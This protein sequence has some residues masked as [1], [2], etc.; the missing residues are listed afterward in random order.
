LREDKHPGFEELNRHSG[1]SYSVITNQSEELCKRKVELSLLESL[2]FE[3]M[4]HRHDSIP[5]AHQRTFE[6]IF[7]DPNTKGKAW[8]DF[9]Q[10]LHSGSG[11]YWIN[12]KAGSGKST[13]MRFVVEH[14]RTR[15]GLEHWAQGGEVG[16]PSF[17]F[18]NSGVAE[19]RSQLGLLQ[20]MLC[21]I[22]ERYTEFIHA[23][24]PDEWNKQIEHA[25]HNIPINVGK[26]S[27]PRLQTAF[28]NLIQ[29]TSERLRLCVFIDGFDEF[30]GD[31]EALAE[32]FLGLSKSPHVKFCISSRPWQVFV[33]TF[34]EFPS[35]RLQDLTHDDIQLYVEDKLGIDERMQCL[36]N[37]ASFKMEHDELVKEV[38]RKADGV[39]LWVTLI[40]KS[41]LRGLRN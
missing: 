10:W 16:L 22:L 13:L 9:T 4:N 35:L 23:V 41:L 11:I 12:G 32:Y 33:E 31:H 6:W 39:F 30:D 7:S 27:L 37:L 19:Q 1:I 29:Q 18:W 21:Q 24:F 8:S 2:R 17:Y 38:V 14:P 34:K 36:S 40:I 15:A 25:R 26:W 5:E 20:T 3:T 28:T